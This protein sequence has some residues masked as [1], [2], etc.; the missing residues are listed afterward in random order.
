ARSIQEG[1]GR[2][3]IGAQ[4]LDV[5][6]KAEDLYAR[7]HL[8]AEPLLRAILV[9]RLHRLEAA[10]RANSGEESFPAERRNNVR[11]GRRWTDRLA[12]LQSET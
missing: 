5:R 4:A 10:V 9:E 12:G 1:A 3:T 7:P 2:P 8:M 11:A 6:F